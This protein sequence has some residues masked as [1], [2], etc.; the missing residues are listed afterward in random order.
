V[1]PLVTK[2]LARE[3]DPDLKASLALIAATI[4]I[5]SATRRAHRR[6]PAARDLEQSQH[7][8]HAAAAPRSAPSPTTTCAARR[9]TR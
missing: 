8:D 2:A 4:Q 3:T 1:L 9:A 5:K 7:Q 6:D